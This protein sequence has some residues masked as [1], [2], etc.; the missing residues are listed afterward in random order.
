L[1]AS[2]S[3]MHV[4][5]L[6]SRALR[7]RSTLTCRLR[8]RSGRA[9][10]D[11]QQTRTLPGSLARREGFVHSSLRPPRPARGKGNLHCR[12]TS[13]VSAGGEL[14]RSARPLRSAAD[15]NYS[16]ANARARPATPVVRTFATPSQSFHHFALRASYAQPRGRSASGGSSSA[17]PPCPRTANCPTFGSWGTSPLPRTVSARAQQHIEPAPR[18]EHQDA[19][20]RSDQEGWSCSW[21][22]TCI[23]EHSAPAKHHDQGNEAQ[24][25]IG[26]AFDQLA[27]VPAPEAVLLDVGR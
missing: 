25:E 8:S 7:A 15:L 17:W 11:Q 16:G 1:Y 20:Q 24:R 18:H 23:A 5:S 4:H 13:R 22:R 9:L 19:A 12:G 3:P 14:R 2:A 21:P 26:V 10:A 6:R 27:L